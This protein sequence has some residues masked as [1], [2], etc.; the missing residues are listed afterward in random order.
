M[1][2]GRADPQVVGDPPVV[3]RDVE[4]RADEDAEAREVA[5]VVE[6]AQR[7]SEPATSWARSTS[8]F[9]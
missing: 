9:E 2:S 4:V 1:G 3:Q 6:R 7:H 5:G 8:R